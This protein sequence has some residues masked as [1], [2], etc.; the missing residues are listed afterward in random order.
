MRALNVNWRL[1]VVGRATSPND[2]FILTTGLPQVRMIQNIDRVQTQCER[3]SFGDLNAF[4]QI[5]I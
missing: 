5:Q 2:R 4:K 1:P 3:L